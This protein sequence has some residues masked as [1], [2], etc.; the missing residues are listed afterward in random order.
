MARIAFLFL[1]A[2]MPGFTQ[3]TIRT[4]AGGG[5]QPPLT[6]IVLEND[7]F[8][9]DAAGTV[10][11]GGVNR[12][13]KITSGGVVSNYIVDA[14]IGAGSNLSFDGQ[15]NLL[16]RNGTVGQI[17]KML[18]GL[19]IVTLTA[20]NGTDTDYTKYGEGAPA[21]TDTA[22]NLYFSSRNVASGPGT[23]YRIMKRDSNGTLTTFAG[24]L[25]G[26]F[27]G[28]SG[29]A[30]QTTIGEVKGLAM[31]SGGN[32]YIGDGTYNRI[33]KVTPGGTVSTVAGNGSNVYSGDGGQATATGLR[34]NS[35]AVDSTGNLYFTG[36]CRVRKIIPGG[37]INTIVGTGICGSDPDGGLAT[38]TRIDATQVAVDAAGNVYFTES[39]NRLRKLTTN[40]VVTTLAGL[41]WPLAPGAGDGGQ[42]SGATLGD[43]S[44]SDVTS[45]WLGNVWISEWADNRLRKVTNTGIISTVGGPTSP[46]ALTGDLT[47][48]V[49]MVDGQQ[50]LKLPPNT[51]V[52]TL[53]G[54]DPTSLESV[55]VD[56]AG[57]LY[58]IDAATARVVRIAADGTRTTIAGGVST[59]LDGEGVAGTAVALTTPASIAVEP[60]GVIYF[61]EKDRHRV[62]ML[63]PSREIYTV[64]GTGVPGFSGDGGP[65]R[66]AQLN[67]P[68]AVAVSLAGDLYISDTGNQRIRKIADGFIYTLAGTGVD[69]FSG[70]GG[71][72]TSAQ[73]G[74]PGKL[75]VGMQN[76]VVYFLENVSR[77]VRSISRPAQVTVTF[78]TTPPGMSLRVAGTDLVGPTAK[79]VDSGSTLQVEAATPV[80]GT[81]SRRVFTSWSDAGA[82][83]H[84]VSVGNGSYTL[85]A[86]YATQYQLQQQVAPST[87]AGSLVATPA[88]ADGFY[89]V[90]QSVQIT[91]VPASGFAFGGFSGDLTGTTNPATLLM[92]NPKGLIATF[93]CGPAL[94]ASSLSA[95]GSAGGGTLNVNTGAGCP[96]TVTS[97]AAWLTG[98]AASGTG[99][100]TISYAYSVNTGAPRT[101]HL[102]ISGLMFTVTQATSATPVVVSGT[103]VNA[104]GVP[105]A[106]TFTARDADGAAN[107]SRLYFLVATSPAVSPNGCHG[108]YD[109][110][111]NGLYLY[112]NTLNVLQGP[113]TPGSAT[114][115]SNSQCTIQG[116]SSAVV[117]AI[118]T[119]L[120]LRIGFTLTGA[121]SSTSQ[122]VYLWAVDA[123]NNGT[124]WVQ[125][126]NW[127]LS[128]NQPPQ[129]VSGA[130]VAPVGSPQTFSM[131][132]RD[133]NGYTNLNRIY[134]LVNSTATVPMGSC[135]GFYDRATNLIFLYNDGLTALLGPLTPGSGS[136]L[137]NSQCTLD[138]ATTQVVSASGTDITLNLGLS[139]RGTFASSAQKIYLWVTDNEAN[140]TGWVQTGTWT[141][142]TGNQPPLLVSTTPTTVNGSPQ[143]FQA[144]A[145]DPNGFADVARIYFL[146]NSSST[147][148][149]GTC[150]GFYDRAANALFLYNDALTAVTGP[151]TPGGGGTLQNGQCTLHGGTTAAS[152]AGTDLTMTLGMSLQGVFATAP[153]KL[154]L[155]VVDTAGAGTGWMQAST[156]TAGGNTPSVVSTTPVLPQGSPQAFT[157][158]VR[159][160]QGVGNLL[161]LYFLLNTSSNISTG[162]CHGFYDKVTN[163]IYLYNDTLT[164]LTGPITPGGNGT[165]SNGQ[166]TVNG[167]TSQLVGAT[168]TDMTLRLG[169]SLQGTF[170]TTAKNVYWWITDLDGNGSGWV[171]GATW[172][173]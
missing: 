143:M 104:A 159:D 91:A 70:D 107:V 33:R 170:G 48:N 29:P 117:S 93:V 81:G 16:F 160:P 14:G 73:I 120:V 45:D 12:I 119:D 40:G 154:H 135:H 96:V 137:Q 155:W 106:F 15:G 7:S 79:Q 75:K 44:R 138:G 60:N 105:Q 49:F 8:A 21:V 172:T 69:G 88:S 97:D 169:L 77:R 85:T 132:V 161:R 58:G 71:P 59:P 89:N 34:V 52:E 35:L 126:S 141:S 31:D 65:G 165:L 162:S 108:F 23:T 103:P 158:L 68:A 17:R 113:V 118:G 134:F 37:T 164:A 99:S 22:G 114:T 32:L 112:N 36:D 27:A 133:P 145:R 166:C 163:G 116:G 111:T 124:G 122:K 156:W 78:A 146:V 28:D 57:N 157:V 42:A 110:A 1:L 61:V 76:G 139:L 101:G 148:Q 168:G 140:G 171:Q 125:T 3:G 18:P 121:F 9:V 115:I 147:I 38:A 90:G 131:A 47:G 94:S 39:A 56:M 100:T 127:T 136:T 83:N 129:V 30:T 13:R 50:V 149:A 64:A 19:V 173:Q 10:Y 24:G 53:P 43:L 82:A 144:V 130:P 74:F 142:G 5:G 63:S 153:Q 25:Q 151:L 55:G 4:F 66:L 102:F 67:S 123:E 20:D 167:A 152:G 86:T 54:T 150:H 6:S 128:T 62:R 26:A 92:D 11:L 109:R 80:V 51:C 2:A 46:T 87:N 84:L 41:G 98:A 95:P 72:A